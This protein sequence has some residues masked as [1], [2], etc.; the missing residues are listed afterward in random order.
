MLPCE[1]TCESSG[2]VFVAGQMAFTLVLLI[3][4]GLFVQTLTRLHGNVGLD[5]RNLVTLSIDPPGIGYSDRALR[6]D[7]FRTRIQ[8]ARAWASARGLTPER[9]SRSLAS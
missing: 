6:A 8:S 5:S 2:S 3:G 4:S 1:P 9:T 7:I